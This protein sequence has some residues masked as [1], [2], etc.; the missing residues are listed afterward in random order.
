MPVKRDYSNGRLDR[1]LGALGVKQVEDVDFDDDDN[2]DLRRGTS[3]FF[4]LKQQEEEEDEK[5]AIARRCL[6]IW[7]VILLLLGAG[8]CAGGLYASTFVYSS[9]GDAVTYAAAGVGGVMFAVNLLGLLGLTISS[10][11]TRVLV[12]Y[13]TFHIFLTFALLLA[14]GFCLV[15]NKSAVAYVSSN[16]ETLL[17]SLSPEKRA[18]IMNDKE[19]ALA[20][21]RTSLYGLGAAAVVIFAVNL[22]A[23]SNVIRLVTPVRA[24]TVLLQATNVSLLPVGVALIAAAA[25]VAD[26]SVGPQTAVAAFAIFILGVFVVALLMVGCVGTLLQSRGI[27]R[28]FMFLTFLLAITFLGFGIAALVQADSVANFITSKWDTLRKVLPPD[29]SG[30]YDRE[31]FQRFVNANLTA[32][33]LLAVVAGLVQ[34]TQMWASYRLRKELRLES[35]LEQEAFEAASKQ[36]ISKEVAETI[37]AMHTKSRAQTVWK[38]KWTKGSKRSRCWIICGCIT[39]CSFVTIAVG[40]AVAAL[41]YSTNC[42]ELV[43]F[44]GINP[45]NGGVNFYPYAVVQNNYTRGSISVRVMSPSDTASGLLYKEVDGSSSASSTA[46]I[47]TTSAYVTATARTSWPLLGRVIRV[48]MRKSALEADM[49]PTDWPTVQVQNWTVLP[50]ESSAALDLASSI[51]TGYSPVDP[52]GAPVSVRG[53]DGITRFSANL[54]SAEPKDKKTIVGYDV[55]CQNA[56]MLV[57]IPASA[58]A[59]VANPS[60]VDV[61]SSQVS[62]LGASLT[63]VKQ[64]ANTI[65]NADTWGITRFYHSQNNWGATAFPGTGDVSLYP[66]GVQLYAGPGSV[67]IDMDFSVDANTHPVDRPRLRRVAVTSVDGPVDMIAPLLG[68][69]GLA[70]TTTTGAVTLLNAHAVCDPADIEPED[71]SAGEA[72]ST[73]GAGAGGGIRLTTDKGGITVEGLDSTDCDVILSGN[74][75]LTRVVRSRVRNTLGGGRLQLLGARGVMSVESSILEVLDIKG[76][77]GSVR[78]SNVTVSEAL[79]VATQTGSVNIDL[80]NMGPRAALQVETDTGSIVVQASQF[81]G[82]ISVVT[83]TGSLICSGTGFDD[84]NPC[85]AASSTTTG[86]SSGSAVQ[87]VESVSVNCKSSS[88][89][90]SVNDCPYLGSITITSTR[91]TVVLNMDKWDRT[92][93]ST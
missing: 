10:S 35:E 15:L 52:V 16:W 58:A 20:L 78:V 67:G 37:A 11:T 57:H 83:G 28:L 34:G 70:V 18:D 59:A 72:V 56:D 46:V 44:S 64:V 53:V 65:A 93:T 90:S 22:A 9:V 82:M 60:T 27:I 88:G 7:D 49:A 12:L 61:T 31:A 50:A 54:I 68:V 76:E 1:D 92:S 5:D 45:Y 63:S 75:A 85:V 21:I 62:L 43:N 42:A 17:A 79:R 48:I 3:S 39:L 40:L 19:G 4:D 74:A 23:V 26:T 89:S 14:G 87:V 91:G 6:K 69:K 51:G 24:Y 41:Y 71:T 13:F 77:D 2:N 81:A 38:Q 73:S 55:A 80:L 86:V 32:V 29:F 47:N 84:A 30:K 8:L 36:L 25:Y 33:G 66:M